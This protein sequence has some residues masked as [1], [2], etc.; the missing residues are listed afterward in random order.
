MIKDDIIYPEY[1]RD[2][3]KKITRYVGKMKRAEFLK[4]ELVQDGVN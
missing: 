2:A 4:D 1:I 3:I